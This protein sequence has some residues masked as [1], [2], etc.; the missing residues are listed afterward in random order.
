MASISKKSIISKE[1]VI[2]TLDCYKTPNTIPLAFVFEPEA[3]LDRR[4]S[5]KSYSI[6]GKSLVA[7][8]GFFT[9]EEGLE[10]REFSKAASF[11]QKI[12]GSQES[13]QCGEI[14]AKMMN[15]KERWQFFANP[16]SA[17]HSLFRLFSFL[18]HALDAKI[19]TLPWCLSDQQ[20][21][22][23]CFAT[24]FINEN[25]KMSQDHGKHQDY[26][27]EN[28]L[29]FSIPSLY[30][31]GENPSHDRFTNGELGRPL[32][33]TVMVY[34]TADNFL[35]EY[36]MGTLFYSQDGKEIT[37]DCRHLQIVMFEGDILHTIEESRIPDGVRTWR[38]SYVFKIILN[39]KKE[40]QTLRQALFNELKKLEDPI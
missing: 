31:I 29:A 2:L 27:P 30:D 34:A 26:N 24:N 23:N 28:G 14:P 25:S 22:S 7:L 32:M 15:G 1:S 6:D 12:F 8:N 38:V 3:I 33:I 37:I 10:L 5:L 20:S 39:P 19:M 21:S 4:L 35:P 36:G 40:D 18:S 11:S 16:P 13:A 9:E 17:I